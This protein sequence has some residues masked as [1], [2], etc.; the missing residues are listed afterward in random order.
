MKQEIRN[1]NKVREEREFDQTQL[2]EAQHG[3]YVH[4]DY[5]AHFFRWGFTRRFIN[6]KSKILDVGCGQDKPLMNVLTASKS[7]VPKLYVGVD[8]NKLPE[9]GIRQWAHWHSEFNFVKRYQELIKLYGQF[10]VVVCYE[11][12][13]HMTRENGLCLLRGLF[14][15]CA[16]DGLII[17][18]T[19]VFDGKAARNHVH[20]WMIIELQKAL[21][22]TGFMITGRFGTFAS[23]QK[24]FLSALSIHEREI[25]DELLAYY[26]HDVMACFLAPLH[27]DESRNNV[28]LC[29]KPI[30]SYKPHRH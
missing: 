26:S 13:E 10:D 7:S 6:P 12:I 14:E 2:R 30:L 24:S 25:Y 27:P 23:H 1:P 18:S 9:V 22:E 3:K 15:C 17:L 19:P 29:Q 21:V 5:A 16:Q 8:L 11:V 4:R 28:W 20:E